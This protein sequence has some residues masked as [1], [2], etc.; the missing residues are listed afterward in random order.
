MHAPRSRKE[1]PQKPD[2]PSGI[3]ARGAVDPQIDNIDWIAPSLHMRSDNIDRIAPSLH[4]HGDNID[5][6][7]PSLH[8]RSDNIDQIAPSLHMR[9]DT[10]P[11]IPNAAVFSFRNNANVP[12]SKT[13][14]NVPVRSIQFDPHD[15]RSSRPDVESRWVV[16][17]RNTADVSKAIQSG[18]LVDTDRLVFY[19]HNDVTTRETAAY[20]NYMEVVNA[21]AVIAAS[22]DNVVRGKLKRAVSS[23]R[24]HSR[25][26][27]YYEAN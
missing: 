9:S 11:S 10:P 15:I 24:C 19:Q 12:H 27:R 6:I 14:L 17:Y 2:A 7:A 18:L 8:M 16:K 22:A 5:R 1:S 13:Q 21:H 26:L 23:G 3:A 4:M 20:R 25:R